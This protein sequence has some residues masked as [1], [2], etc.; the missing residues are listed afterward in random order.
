[1]L[2]TPTSI[3]REKEPRI[4]EASWI[5]P[6]Y[7]SAVR[8]I[9]KSAEN[10]LAQLFPAVAICR[11]G[12]GRR[13]KKRRKKKQLY[14]LLRSIPELSLAPLSRHVFPSISGELQCL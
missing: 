14:S 5:L 7:F 11:G 10:S 1:M 6:F 12:S 9:G 4:Q 13:K 8:L 2:S 3:V